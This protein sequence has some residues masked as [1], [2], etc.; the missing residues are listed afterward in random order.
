MIPTIT[1]CSGKITD[2]KGD[3][4]ICGSETD[5]TN[6]SGNT[7]KD[8]FEQAGKEL[9]TELLAIGYC[10]LGN[11]IITR[12]YNL[13]V[14]HIIFVPTKDSYN[15][16]NLMDSKLLHQAI[17]SGLT[18]AG[19]YRIK[20]LAMPMLNSGIK[21]RPVWD[22]IIGK[23]IGNDQPKPLT[24]DEVLSIVMSVAKDFENSSIKEISIYK[25]VR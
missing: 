12:G 16:E 7:V 19:I 11:A 4:L 15:P 9:E 6:R 1:L 8:I 3:T 17:R 24:D 5:L 23:F 2:F 22:K 13:K 20:S 25:F 21:K 18:L 10:A 14:K